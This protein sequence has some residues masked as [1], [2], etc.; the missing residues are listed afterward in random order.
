MHG[1][2][3]TSWV[4]EIKTYKAI[5]VMEQYQDSESALANS[6]KVIKLLCEDFSD[7]YTLRISNDEVLLENDFLMGICVT[8]DI[9]DVGFFVPHAS[10]EEPFEIFIDSDSH[11]IF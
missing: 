4:F 10:I 6:M 5:K 2:H 1:L 3:T 8:C 11:H 9:L 7:S